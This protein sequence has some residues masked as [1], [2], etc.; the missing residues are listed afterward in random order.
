MR[1]KRP[2]CAIVW[3]FLSAALAGAVPAG[4][5]SYAWLDRGTDGDSIA[6]R[7]PPP[8]GYERIDAAPGSFGS[9]LRNLPLKKEGSPVY[10]YDGRRKPNQDAHFAVVDIDT[11]TKN[12]Q[13]CAD[14]VIRLNAEYLYSVGNTRAIHY[15]ATSGQ[16]I[17]FSRWVEGERPLVHG[18]RLA[19]RRTRERGSSYAS[20][21]KY[22]ATVFAYAGTYSLGRELETVTDV[23]DMRIG[24]VF[25]KGGFPGHAV[26]VVDMAVH[27]ETGKKVF[28]LA[29]SYMPAQ[30]MHVLKNPNAPGSSPWYELDFGEILYTP[31]WTFSAG[32]LKR[33]SEDRVRME[34]GG[35]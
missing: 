14:A 1:L 12:L 4:S 23:R 17:D 13:Q 28:L 7:L 8:E 34:P 22:L 21:R 35:K 19:W 11:G 5:G 20:F 24:D 27:P 2:H 32:D 10:L 3:M 6:E 18:D 9:W 16:R 25:I 31:E 26:I 29:Q 30:D 33:F 15:N